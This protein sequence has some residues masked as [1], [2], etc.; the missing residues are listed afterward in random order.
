MV[1]PG[2][3]TGEDVDKISFSWTGWSCAWGLVDST[4][5]RRDRIDPA[6]DGS[7]QLLGDLDE[8]SEVSVC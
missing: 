5:D 8:A 6:R 2:D 3:G 1:C 4:V 7:D